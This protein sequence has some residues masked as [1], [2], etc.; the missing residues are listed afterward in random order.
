[1]EPKARQFYLAGGLGRYVEKN[2]YIEIHRR[3]GG[4]QPGRTQSEN[5]P[6]QEWMQVQALRIEAAPECVRRARVRIQTRE[7]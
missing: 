1:M 2:W 7:E 4:W 5:A 6:G 3:A